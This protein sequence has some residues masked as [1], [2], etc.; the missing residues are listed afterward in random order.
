MASDAPPDLK[1]LIWQNEKSFYTFI[2]ISV[3]AAFI[4]VYGAWEI[5][6]AYAKYKDAQKQ[7]NLT[8][9][10]TSTDNYDLVKKNDDSQYR[11]D[12]IFAQNLQRTL[13]E[14]KTYNE[15]LKKYYKENRPEEVPKDIIDRRILDPS[16]DKY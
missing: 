11:D 5:Y 3:M 9:K 8:Y 10:P 16:A 6:K 7:H 14:Y 4:A 15:V 2:G 12:T 1:A 13:N